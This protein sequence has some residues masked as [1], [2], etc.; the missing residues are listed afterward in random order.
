MI[1]LASGVVIQCSTSRG[2]HALNGAGLF[3]ICGT[4]GKLLKQRQ[5]IK[6]ELFF[7]VLQFLVA[8]SFDKIE[9]RGIETQREVHRVRGKTQNYRQPLLDM[10]YHS[11]CCELSQGS[12]LPSLFK[13]S[14]PFLF[15][16]GKHII[17]PRMSVYIN[18]CSNH[19]CRVLCLRLCITQDPR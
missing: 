11:L 12:I 19:V 3:S 10:S 7:P 17:V 8:L 4:K 5:S 9:M 16:Y 13:S 1:A 14:L 2:A 15:L 6:A 18:A